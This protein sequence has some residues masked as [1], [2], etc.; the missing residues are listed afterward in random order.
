[1]HEIGHSLGLWHQQQRSDR[2]D[3]IE[4]MW[5]NIGTFVG[6]FYMHDSA[7][8]GLPYDYGS[9]MQYGSKVS[10]FVLP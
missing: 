8:F 1:M 3:Y 7:N 10:R 6:Q 9:V 2:D 4:V 5:G